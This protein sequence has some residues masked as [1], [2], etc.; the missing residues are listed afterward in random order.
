M[1][2]L[3]PLSKTLIGLAVV[4]AMASAVWHLALK[5]ML[6][7]APAPVPTASVAPPPAQVISSES[8]SPP[9][10]PAANPTP[11]NETVVAPP[12]KPTA[13]EAKGPEANLS[14][15]ENAEAGRKALN[16]G[17]HALARA[18]LEK[19][20]QG[21]DG[22]AACLLGEMTMKGQG[23][24]AADQQ[25]AADLFQLAQSRNIICFASGQ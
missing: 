14:P 8:P 11:S 7:E 22:P 16:S 19:A 6:S 18:H 9:P 10:P 15:A 21:G 4:G 17:N 20:V 5:D 2:S 1:A 24:L 3:T 13:A 12:A 23:G 25:K